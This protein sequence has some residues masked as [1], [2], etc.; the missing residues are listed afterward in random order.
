MEQQV[1][2]QLQAQVIIIPPGRDPQKWVLIMI[3]NCINYD[4]KLY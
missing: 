2:V 1:Q 3:E 4:R